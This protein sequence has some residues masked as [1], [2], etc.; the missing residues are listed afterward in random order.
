MW[1]PTDGGEWVETADSRVPTERVRIAV[2]SWASA[3]HASS[4]DRLLDFVIRPAFIPALIA[5]EQSFD[6]GRR[7]VTTGTYREASAPLTMFLRNVFRKREFRPLQGEAI[8]NI[9]A[10]ERLR[11]ATSNRSGQEP[12]LPARRPP[13]ARPDAGRGPDQSRSS[14]IR[15]KGYVRTESIARFRSPALSKALN[16][17]HLLRRVERGEYQFVLHSPERLQSTRVPLG[18]PCPRGVFARE[19]RCHR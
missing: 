2:Q 14:R 12:H 8:L 3:F 6:L 16:A 10:T 9:S 19:S 18:A 17:N 15:S 7:A 5:T 13:D 11:R 1:T 4:D